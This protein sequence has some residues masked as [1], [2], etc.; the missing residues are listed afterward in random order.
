MSFDVFLP[1]SGHD[2]SLCC[3]LWLC[4]FSPVFHAR[5]DER[6]RMALKWRENESW[7]PARTRVT[8]SENPFFQ[9]IDKKGRNIE[10]VLIRPSN[11]VVVIQAFAIELPENDRRVLYKFTP[12]LK[13]RLHPLFFE[14]DIKRRDRERKTFFSS[15][16]LAASVASLAHSF[17]RTFTA[18]SATNQTF[19]LMCR[20]G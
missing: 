1:F 8:R 11:S 6:R 7:H 17:V 16:S 20:S 4:V 2:F 13:D 14:K 12:L 18:N 5:V 10:G 3:K 15:S 9:S 19:Y